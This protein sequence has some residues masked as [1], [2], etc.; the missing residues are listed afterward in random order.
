[1]VLLSVIGWLVKLPLR[2]L[3]YKITFKS[4]RGKTVHRQFDSWPALCS[5]LKRN[6][7]L[8]DIVNDA[9]AVDRWADEVMQRVNRVV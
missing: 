4:V 6:F 8:R 5:W 9:R 3:M 1:M 2:I 7:V